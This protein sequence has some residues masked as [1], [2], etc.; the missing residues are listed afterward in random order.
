MPPLEASGDTF[1]NVLAFLSRLS[2]VAP[3][4]P[5][6]G[7]EPRANP[8]SFAEIVHPNPGEWL[9]YDGQLSGNRFSSLDQ[10][11]R[12]NVGKWS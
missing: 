7:A 9:T 3:D 12:A 11:N 5:L 1:T 2:G 8:I 10:L 6:S 4:I